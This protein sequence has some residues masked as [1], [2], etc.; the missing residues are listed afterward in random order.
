MECFSTTVGCCC[1]EGLGIGR[2]VCGSGFLFRVNML[3]PCSSCFMALQV[4][5]VFYVFYVAS[6]RSQKM[7]SLTVPSSPNSRISIVQSAIKGLG[8]GLGGVFVGALYGLGASPKF[9]SASIVTGDS[10]DLSHARFKA[11]VNLNPKP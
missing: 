1:S 6:V 9:P 2:R 4:A 5:L 10:S 11:G 7:P 3:S 8:S